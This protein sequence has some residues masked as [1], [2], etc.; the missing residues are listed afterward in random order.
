LLCYVGS[1]HHS[2]H[3]V[4]AEPTNT[5]FS[6]PNNH[7]FLRVLD[8]IVIRYVSIR[9]VLNF[10]WRPVRI[11]SEI[12]FVEVRKML[13]L[14]S[15]MSSSLSFVA[16]TCNFD[17]KLPENSLS[18]SLSSNKNWSLSSEI[19]PEIKTPNEI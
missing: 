15:S 13:L 5:G 8:P 11:F 12:R 17:S 9:S 16:S 6:K 1:L 7:T 18:D 3:P 10:L 14:S 19:M 4:V 2:R